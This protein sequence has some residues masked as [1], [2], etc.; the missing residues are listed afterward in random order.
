MSPI[1]RSEDAGINKFCTE[2]AAQLG[3]IWPVQVIAS[4]C[5]R[6]TIRAVPS[7]SL[8]GFYRGPVEPKIGDEGIAIPVRE[9]SF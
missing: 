7:P 3:K 2:P 5:H 6:M 9:P 8:A 4:G 1:L